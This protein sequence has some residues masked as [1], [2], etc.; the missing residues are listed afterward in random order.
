MELPVY[1]KV[2]APTC[3]VKGINKK[4]HIAFVEAELSNGNTVYIRKSTLVWLLQEDERLCI[5]R[6]FCV[7]E[8]QPFSTSTCNMKL[9]AKTEDPCTD[10]PT[11]ASSVS[12]G[13]ICVCF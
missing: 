9:I 12:I 2:S 3:N 13:D 4:K 7:R 1:I 5:D 8:T 6:I 10:I 11:K